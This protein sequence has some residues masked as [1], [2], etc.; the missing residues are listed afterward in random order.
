MVIYAINEWFF[1]TGQ[2]VIQK[3]TI[4]V[5]LIDHQN[6]VVDLKDK[7][8]YCCSGRVSGASLF[9][10]RFVNTTFDDC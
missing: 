3:Y 7:L 6:Y 8:C 5:Q 2:L 10:L 4:M 1:I 9:V